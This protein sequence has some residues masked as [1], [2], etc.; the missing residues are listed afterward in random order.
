MW[1]FLQYVFSH[2]AKNNK[3]DKNYD[4]NYF[5]KYNAYI[6]CYYLKNNFLNN[7]KSLL[8][9]YLNKIRKSQKF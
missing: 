7:L 5:L 6:F 2:I 4:K 8:V 9:I 1:K 3:N